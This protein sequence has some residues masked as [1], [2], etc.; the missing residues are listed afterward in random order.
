MSADLRHRRL[1]GVAICFLLL[2]ASG[3]ATLA[4][5][6]LVRRR[7]RSFVRSLGRTAL[8]WSWTTAAPS[9]RESRHHGHRP[10]RCAAAGPWPVTSGA[11]SSLGGTLEAGT[12][13]GRPI[14]DP[15][16]D[17]V[18]MESGPWWATARRG[19]PRRLQA[20]ILGAAIG[21]SVELVGPPEQKR[22]DSGGGRVLVPPKSEAPT[23]PPAVRHLDPCRTRRLGSTPDVI[24]WA[25]PADVAALAGE[26]APHQRMLYRLVRGE[27]SAALGSALR[28]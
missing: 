28:A 16:I 9:R 17:R 14:A 10:A 25:S 1:H 7:R 23:E 6:I 20:A 4:L 24:A 11:S 13:S 19:R 5:S 18:T 26:G 2:L 21:D 8:I 27:S 3:A 15:G 22:E 12:V